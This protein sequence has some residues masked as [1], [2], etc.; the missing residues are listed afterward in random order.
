MCACRLIAVCELKAL[1]SDYVRDCV[2][3]CCEST[4]STLFILLS[5]GSMTKNIHLLIQVLILQNWFTLS[6]LRGSFVQ[7]IPFEK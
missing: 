3:Y 6:N 2:S 4:R 7:N 5:G 1:W